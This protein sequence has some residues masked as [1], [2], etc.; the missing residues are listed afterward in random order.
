[1]PW[2]TK[3]LLWS[4]A[5][6]AAVAAWAS[7]GQTLPAAL[8]PWADANYTQRLFLKVQTP[9][10]AGGA[11]LVEAAA[12][13]CVG[14]PLEIAWDEEGAH[15]EPVL[16]IGEDSSTC[17]IQ[18]R[19]REDGYNV[20]VS[21][22]THPGLRRFCLYYSSGQPAVAHCSPSNFEAVP[23]SV[24]LQ[25]HSGSNDF[26]FTNKR[27][28]TL[29]R[30]KELQELSARLLGVRD[31]ENID[32][33]TCPFVLVEAEPQGHI[34]K[35][36]N[37]PGYLAVYDAY[38]HAPLSG[39]Y[40]FALDTPGV[41]L[42]TLDGNT[43]LTASV[44]EA[45][46]LPFTLANSVSLTEGVHRLAVYYAEANPERKTNA[47]LTR[48]GLRL[49]WQPPFCQSLLCI[50][51]Q[52]FLAHLPV[53]IMRAEK[54]K[55]EAVPFIQVETVAQVLVGAN[56]GPHQERQR[57]LLLAKACGAAGARLRIQPKGGLGTLS[58]PGA[59]SLCAWVPA[60]T[61]IE[62]ALDGPGG[63]EPRKFR[64]PPLGAGVLDLQGELAIK[65]AP[66]F[67]YTEESGHI[68]M[69]AMLSPPPVIVPKHY[70]ETHILPPLPRP[71]G[72]F[73]LSWE[74]NDL[75]PAATPN[76]AGQTARLAFR[77]KAPAT[78]LEDIRRKL[79]ISF[80]ASDLAGWFKT[81]MGQLV[82]HFTI[83]DVEVQTPRFR[84]LDSTQFWPGRIEAAPDHL[85]FRADHEP[86]GANGAR[87]P[88]RV[89][90]VMEHQDEADYR[91]W[92][93]LKALTPPEGH[94]ALFVG[95]PLVEDVAWETDGAPRT[96]LPA[97]LAGARPDLKWTWVCVPG[98]YRYLPIFQ[99]LA[100]LE[101]YLR[102]HP[103]KVP[104]RVVVSLGTGD[105][106]RQTPLYAFERALAVLIE[107]LRLAGGK[108]IEIAFIDVVPKPAHERQCAL[109]QEHITNIL[110]QYHVLELNVAGLWL[111]EPDWESRYSV[112][113]SPGVRVYGPEP[114]AQSVREIARE[115]L[116]LME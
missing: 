103:G 101:A 106:E 41:A 110:R 26:K 57:V 68:H 37:P 33:P 66:D 79:R 104:G 55:P 60:G 32:Q 21:F 82:L 24:R 87:D 105:V 99:M 36:E 77:G 73:A 69:E 51:P 78:P 70:L 98:P 53:T 12:A 30:F 116:E 71:M 56:S 17:P 35:V 96:G 111:K 45:G 75:A 62:V 27:P 20:E 50:P 67:L 43:V 9:G 16:L 85:E 88:E 94:E 19:A 38:L 13:A 15:V 7:E 34:R 31:V 115:I 84:L 83:G 114:N 59:E 107:R 47:D 63:G 74:L 80:L 97:E 10:E 61:Q 1:M 108:E 5:A 89:L 4:A 102:A 91:R 3:F 25:G 64:F 52:A 14:L 6:L 65:S 95:D 11:G 2:A 48:F 8:V 49:H 93:P 22:G 113:S 86:P 54:A 23:L 44:P 72:E 46:R 81:G 18:V 28:L 92:G 42:V 100:D 76:P 40:K 112:E 39:T 109:Y 90:M 58:A 29:E